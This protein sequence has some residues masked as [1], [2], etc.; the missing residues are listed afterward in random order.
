LGEES[1][2]SGDGGSGPVRPAPLTGPVD[3]AVPS[4]P[5]V[6][7][8]SVR[9]VASRSLYDLGAAVSAVPALA[10]LVAP[11]PLRANPHDL[12]D[13]GVTPGGS[14]RLRSASASVLATVVPDPSLPRKVVSADFNRRLQVPGVA[15]NGEAGDTGPTVADLIDAEAPVVEMRMETP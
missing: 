14:V 10:G 15:S 9:L 3:L 12:D 1:A 6:D 2:E 11:S 8:Y 13:L 5:P 7:G 4:L